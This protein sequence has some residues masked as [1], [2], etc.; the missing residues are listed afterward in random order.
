MKS[1]TDHRATQRTPSFARRGDENGKERKSR[2][3][4]AV[5]DDGPNPRRIDPDRPQPDGKNVRWRRSSEQTA[6]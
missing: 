3:P 4:A 1:V 6:P 5:R 2:Q